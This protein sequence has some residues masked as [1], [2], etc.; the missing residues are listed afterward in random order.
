MS[1]YGNSL[2]QKFH[3]VCCHI[4]IPLN[5]MEGFVN[6][7]YQKWWGC[8]DVVETVPNSMVPMFLKKSQ[9]ERFRPPGVPRLAQAGGTWKISY[10]VSRIEFGD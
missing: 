6:R 5:F 1:E 2:F 9:L 3:G 8:M 10:A 4:L 7:L